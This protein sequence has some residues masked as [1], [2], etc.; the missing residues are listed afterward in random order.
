VATLA[1]DFT[2]IIKGVPRGSWVALS[3]DE[4]Q[5]IAYGPDMDRVINQAHDEGE[6]DPIIMRVPESNASLFL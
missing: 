4:K 5:L 3:N 1:I 2:A 6:S